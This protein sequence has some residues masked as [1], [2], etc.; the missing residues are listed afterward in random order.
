MT[1]WDRSIWRRVRVAPIQSI[2]FKR[3]FGF[4]RYYEPASE[5]S[6]RTGCSFASSSSLACAKKTEAINWH[7]HD[8]AAESDSHA[9]AM[10]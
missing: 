8:L 4:E 10:R 7:E 2:A 9:Q 1:Q 3:I 6:E 5:L